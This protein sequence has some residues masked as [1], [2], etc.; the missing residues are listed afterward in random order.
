MKYFIKIFVGTIFILTLVMFSQASADEGQWGPKLASEPV[1]KAPVLDGKA[2][3]W[4][5]VPVVKVDVKSAVPKDPKNY[6]GSVTVEISAVTKG[7]TIYFLAQWA[8]DTKDATHQTLR[9]NKDKEIYEEGKDREDRLALRF[10]MGGDFATCM[11]SG[12]EYKADLWHW[13]AFRSQGA[14]VAHDKMHIF[15]LKKIPMAK[16]HT[17]K[18][19]KK[20]WVS[21]PSDKGSKLYK[22]QRPIDFIEDTV[23]R[24]IPNKNASGSIADIKSAAGWANG[25]WTVEMS[26]KL[27]T[28]HEDDVRFEKGKS[29]RAGAA[30]FN[31]TGDNH[32][33]T[34]AFVLEVK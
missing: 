32:H 16:E 6:T 13:K 18:D 3:E 10:D 8:D 24:Y 34:G 17:G 31:H 11:L 1:E 27:D 14:G 20:I 33:S 21:R 29:Y 19:G 2:D 4:Q 26:R 28:G 23:P 9:W 7:D 12:T 30:D 5:N 25:K 15:S 22:S